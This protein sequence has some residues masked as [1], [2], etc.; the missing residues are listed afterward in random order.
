AFSEVE[1]FEMLG[2]AEAVAKGC[3]G[4]QIEL[5]VGAED[6]NDVAEAL[7]LQRA[8]ER[9]HTSEAASGHEGGEA[10]A[11]REGIGSWESGEKSHPGSRVAEIVAKGPR[12]D[13]IVHPG[14][15]HNMVVD[16]RDSGELH[17]LLCSLQDTAGRK[18]RPEVSLPEG[19]VGFHDCPDF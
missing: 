14:R 11:G 9:A 15:D 19:F 7:I 13:V 16:M 6:E 3:R 12:C 18:S 10:T 2:L 17:T 4:T 5:H 8:V 1:G